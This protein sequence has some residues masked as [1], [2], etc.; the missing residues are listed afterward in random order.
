MMQNL[1]E[2]IDEFTAGLENDVKA[3]YKVL[4]DNEP[5]KCLILLWIMQTRLASGQTYAKE[6]CI[7]VDRAS[8]PMILNSQYIKF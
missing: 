2:L 5:K 1:I 8:Y 3:M 6:H 7:C 4:E